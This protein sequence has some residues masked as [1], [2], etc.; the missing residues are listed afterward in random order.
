MPLSATIPI[1]AL[2]A[3]KTCF[4]RQEHAFVDRV[5]RSVCQRLEA[6]EVMK[7]ATG[8][9]RFTPRI[10]RLG[11]DIEPKERSRA[12]LL[13]VNIRKDRRLKADEDIVLHRSFYGNAIG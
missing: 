12:V 13:F 11:N 4:I 1:G 9:V 5:L 8:I 10:L 6:P 2:A 7:A 3:G